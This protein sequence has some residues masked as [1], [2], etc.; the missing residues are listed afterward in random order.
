MNK[1]EQTRKT[2]YTGVYQNLNNKTFGYRVKLGTD[3]ATGKSI[4]EHHRGFR[5]ANEAHEARTAALK[6][7]HDLGALTNAHMLYEQILYSR[8]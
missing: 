1:K 3:R 2:K 4:T 8:I 5:T 7:K 6:K